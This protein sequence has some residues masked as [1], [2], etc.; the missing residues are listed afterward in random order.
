MAI[1]FSYVYLLMRYILGCYCYDIMPAQLGNPKM[2]G[3][4]IL[5]F[6]IPAFCCV[7]GHLHCFKKITLVVF[8]FFAT[9]FSV[10]SIALWRSLMCYE[11][12]PAILVHE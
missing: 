7:G 10:V 4:L 3:P 6:S 2:K 11:E 12:I 1:S 8:F 5:P 9:Y